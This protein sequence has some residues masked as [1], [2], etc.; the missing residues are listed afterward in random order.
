MLS[1]VTSEPLSAGAAD[2][3]AAA[4]A[5]AFRLPEPLAPLAQLAYNYRW[6]WTMGGPELF[7]DVDATR[8][9]LT[10][11][12][13][14]RLLQEVP[15]RVLERLAGDERFVGRMADVHAIV[16]S[17]LGRPYREGAV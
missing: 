7:A 2:V 12:N 10:H 11:A 15:P 1:P 16:A 8:W 9:G 5:L 3:E 4:A 13:P 17:D 6:S 14:V